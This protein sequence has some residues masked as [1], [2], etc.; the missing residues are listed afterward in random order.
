MPRALSL[1]SQ[2]SASKQIILVSPI[3]YAF[4]SEVGLS[5]LDTLSTGGASL[6][7]D[8]SLMGYASGGVRE[9]AGM[10]SSGGPISWFSCYWA[11][12]GRRN[13]VF[14]H[15]F[16]N[17]GWIIDGHL[18]DLTDLRDKILIYIQEFNNNL[19]LRSKYLSFGCIKLHQ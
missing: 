18:S 5:L 7:L 9:L 4:N 17:L 3:I 1:L 13:I 16:G 11:R 8:V 19:Y 14:D 10:V 12:S 6:I 2:E 15:Q